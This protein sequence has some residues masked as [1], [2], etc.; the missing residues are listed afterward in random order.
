MK[1]HCNLAES[2]LSLVADILLHWLTFE[3]GDSGVGLEVVRE[4]ARQQAHVVL[5]C[6]ELSSGT[7][8]AAAIRASVP[9]AQVEPMLCDLASLASVRAFVSSFHEKRTPLNGLICN[10]GVMFAPKTASRDN[11]EL[12]F[13]VNHLAHFLL[14]NLLIDDLQI[15]KGRIVGN[16]VSSVCMAHILL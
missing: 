13:A 10:A 12:H 6:R 15:T 2:S 9:N 4:L 14:V 16:A 7:S 1:C 11:L 3:G 5:C 8:V